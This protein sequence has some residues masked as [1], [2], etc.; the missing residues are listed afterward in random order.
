MKVQEWL[1]G[2][3][4]AAALLAAFGI[5]GSAI[6]QPAAAPA[7]P[8]AP[9]AGSEEV[10]VT[11]SRI[12]GTPESAALPVDVISS[13]ELSKQGSP[14]AVEL[15][16]S[17]PVS[18]GVLG[19][20]NQFD[21]RSQGTGGVASVNLRG[22]S[23][24]RTLVLL[25]SKRLVPIGVGVGVV[26]VN[27]IPSAAI[28]RVEVLKDG[29]AAT[30]GSDAVAGVVNFITRKDQEGFIVSADYKWMDA[31]DGDYTVSG[32]FGYQ[33]DGVRLLAAI[34][35]QHRSEL[36]AID[37]DWAIRSYAENPEGGW[38]SGGNPSV[39]LPVTATGAPL[40]AVRAD[41]SCTALGG[42]LVYSG[43]L[44][45]PVANQRCAG[46]YTNWDA[47]A[48]KEDRYQVYFEAGF[49]L[50][51]SVELELSA[52]YGY[53]KQP[54]SKTS[55]TYL[56]TQAPSSAVTPAGYGQ[57]VAGWFVPAANP[58]LVAYAAQNAGTLPAGAAGVVFPLLLFRPA[59]LGGNPLFQNTATDLGSS[60][61]YSDSEAVRLTADLHWQITDSIDFDASLTYHNYDRFLSGYDT[62]GDR[63]ELALRGF[64]GANCNRT[65][66]TPGANG[67]LWFNPFGNGVALNPAT[68][69]TNPGFVSSLANSDEV[70]AWFFQ[71]S[72]ATY[73]TELWVFDAAVSGATGWDLDGGPVE[74][75]VGGQYR[76]TSLDVNYFDNNDIAVTPCRETPVNGNLGPCAPNAAGGLAASANGAFAFLGTNGDVSVSGDV[77][78]L[79]GE[80][81]LPISDKLNLQLAAR[82]EDYGGSVGSTFDPKATL[83]WQATDWLAFRGSIGTTF[84]GPPDSQLVNRS[85]T[86]LQIIGSSFKPVDVFGN[87]ALKPEDATNYSAG[88]IVKS[89]MVSLNVD[90]WRYDIQGPIVGEP[91]SGMLSALFP[92]GLPTN[93][94]VPAFAALQS[95]FTFNGACSLANVA[96]LR[97]SIVNGA[98]VQ[99]SGID[100]QLNLSFDDVAGGNL[101]MGG[102]ATYVLNYD[103]ADQFVE[104]VVVQPGF[105]A[106]GKLNYQTTAYPVPKW[107]AQ[108]YLDFAYD[109]F[110]ARLTVNFIDSYIDQRTAPFLAR[111]DLFN[112]AT[113]SVQ[114]AGKII[115]QT[116]TLDFTL[117]VD[118]PMDS[119]ATFTVINMTDE[120]PSF[121]R[122]DYNYDPF[123]GNAY[124]RQFKIGLTTRF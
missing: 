20:S 3:A 73:E 34:G 122:L 92:T 121:A 83:R 65:L 110:N 19:D 81:Q 6:A 67:C 5:V 120:D 61:A 60:E 63:F 116:V 16:K 4:S 18:N 2:G 52:L 93:C 54:V 64:G 36:L 75:S 114:P 24:V 8:A 68:G 117:Q 28:G 107:K 43:T 118:L 108:G 84:R 44:A 76:R 82:Y 98:D 80:L 102:T 10:V 115:E 50:S 57:A 21:S 85:V 96:R 101:S 95:R 123:T 69:Q 17:L 38:T 23:P 74:F 90:Y 89:D 37:R 100:F 33:G 35:Y 104:G 46:Q 59:L 55:P 41:V 22:L 119:T 94:G 77:Y 42:V 62:F 11:G 99:T 111:V 71:K 106:A 45:A 124:G 40:A 7:A 97:T 14:T 66:N 103:V 39:F 87:P 12:R 27:M 30:Y 58:G 70:I 15:I 79:F 49:D 78:A 29:A 88:V 32:S 91:V 86:S 105:D 26:D 47:L 112:L 13:Q 109:I 113:G 48:E 9:A 56:L 25:N 1:R 31:S 51:P 53:T 72:E